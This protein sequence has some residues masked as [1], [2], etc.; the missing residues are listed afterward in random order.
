QF[1]RANLSLFNNEWSNV[2]DFSCPTSAVNWVALCVTVGRVNPE[3]MA[4]HYRSP[5][6][7]VVQAVELD[8]KYGAGMLP[9]S[10]GS[11]GRIFGETCVLLSFEPENETAKALT[12]VVD[13]ALVIQAK[14]VK[15]LTSELRAFFDAAGSPW[16]QV[17]E[18]K[19]AFIAI[20]M[21][22]TDILTILEP[23]LV[24][25]TTLEPRLIRMSPSVGAAV[26]EVYTIFGETIAER[27]PASGWGEDDR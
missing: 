14:K 26:G 16:K 8:A 9:P 12:A 5:P 1:R 7:E 15:T 19:G 11:A 18:R 10:L 17:A 23:I 20:E 24:N 2:H 21:N 4:E 13:K 25:P 27:K 3:L 6:E 22:G